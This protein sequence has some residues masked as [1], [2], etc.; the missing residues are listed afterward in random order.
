MY[1]AATHG[2]FGKR[3]QLAIIETVTRLR[4]RRVRE[5]QALL[6][7]LGLTRSEARALGMRRVRERQYDRHILEHWDKRVLVGESLSFRF[8]GAAAGHTLVV[9]PVHGDGEAGSW[10]IEKEGEPLGCVDDLA[11]VRALLVR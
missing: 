1:Q 11:R 9:R 8:D 6:D 7:G 4:R 3:N 5:T 2:F 10:L